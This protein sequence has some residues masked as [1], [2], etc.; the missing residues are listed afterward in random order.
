MKKKYILTALRLLAVIIFI[1]ITMVAVF[2]IFNLQEYK[3]FPIAF[4][5]ILLGMIAV[6]ALILF[7]DAIYKKYS[8]A[9][10]APAIVVSIFYYI[11]IM[12]TTF[13]LKGLWEYLYMGV[14]VIIFLVYLALTLSI[15]KVAIIK[16]NDILRQQNEKSKTAALKL[17]LSEIEEE[18]HKQK[19]KISTEEYQSIQTAYNNMAERQRMST[20]F[21]RI[22]RAEIV[23]SENIIITEMSSCL[24]H[25]KKLEQ[26]GENKDE[27]CQS[28]IKSLDLIYYLIR[29][30]EKTIIQ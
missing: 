27:I 26:E 23:A 15:C 8:S 11:T 1:A 21:G 9:I 6:S 14:S 16:F 10:Y 5:L 29:K 12:I 4:I 30:R 17:L 24:I 19:N 3:I 13:L 20:P 7:R 28:L 2:E 25:I 18:L 22:L